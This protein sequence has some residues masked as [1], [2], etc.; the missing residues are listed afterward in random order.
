M[1]K[2]RIFIAIPL[3]ETL[4]KEL[5]E[6]PRKLPNL[7][8]R[9]IKPENFHLTLIPPMYLDDE[10]LARLCRAVSKRAAEVPSFEIEFEKIIYGPPGKPV[11]M[12]W[13][14]GKPDEKLTELKNV[15]S[16]AILET[17]I[18]YREEIRPLTPHITLCRM[19][20]YKWRQF[21]PKPKVDQPFHRVFTVDT[22]NI[23]ESNLHRSGAEYVILESIPLKNQRVH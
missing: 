4:K 11:R 12:I 8:C 19:D 7:P 16:K 17:R 10:E 3:P 20:E 9:W 6:L 1:P 23:M 13:L 22:L 18:P 15:I 2:S 14:W 21:E 5:S